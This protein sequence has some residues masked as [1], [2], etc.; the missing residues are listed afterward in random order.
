MNNQGV[1]I[2]IP[3]ESEPKDFYK[4]EQFEKEVILRIEQKKCV[5]LV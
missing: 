4:M 5:I 1:Q 3:D 2:E